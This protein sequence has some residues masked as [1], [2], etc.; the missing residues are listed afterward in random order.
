MGAR[1]ATGA[2]SDERRRHGESMSSIEPSI[3]VQ[4][5]RLTA[6]GELGPE[7][8]QVF[9]DAIHKLTQRD[10]GV[11]VVDMGGVA[12]I[13]SGYVRLLALAMVDARKSGR[14]I[15]VRASDRVIRLLKMGGIDRLGTIEL[16]DN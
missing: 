15:V 16:I 9:E 11:Y 2:P 8:E 4:G 5:S 10:S 12:Y 14:S 6:R 13:S 1:A 3:D 7:M